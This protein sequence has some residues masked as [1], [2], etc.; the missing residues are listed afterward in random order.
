MSILIALYIF[1]ILYATGAAYFDVKTRKIP[2]EY[3][4]A[5]FI[6]ALIIKIIMGISLGWGN[7]WVSLIGLLLGFTIFF[8]FFIFRLAG[9]GDVKLLAVAGLILGWKSFIWVFIF[10]SVI[11]AL[12]VFINYFKI[13]YVIFAVPNK[14]L[15]EKINL[16]IDT[17]KLR[18]N[19]KNPY[20]L[21]FAIGSLVFLI[22]Y[23]YITSLESNF[24][25][26]YL[27]QRFLT[28]SVFV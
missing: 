27:K 25:L 28:D 14:P 26:D 9:A 16:F 3:N 21:S 5:F 17:V 12:L 2:N 22:F 8:P 7:L 1:T 19:Q 10:T 15:E 6:L 23:L 4:L 20:A 18:R 13:F 24:F 11:D